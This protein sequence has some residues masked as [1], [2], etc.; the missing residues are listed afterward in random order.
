MS[1]PPPK[2]PLLPSDNLYSSDEIARL[3]VRAA[4]TPFDDPEL[5]FAVL[6]PKE[7]TARDVEVTRAQLAEDARRPVTLAEFGPPGR[8]DVLVN[9][10]Y[11]RV[12]PHVTLDRFVEEFVRQLGL[13]FLARQRGDMNGRPVEDALVR[14]PRVEGAAPVV[15]R[16]TASRLGP[17]VFLLACS[18]READHERFARGFGAAAVSFEPGA[19]GW[20]R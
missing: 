1:P 13:E 16:L 5:R 7:W 11:A 2:E 12:P 8:A 17:R 4:V 3:F 15:S 19:R 18:C 10:S 20:A 6:V 9:V 14:M